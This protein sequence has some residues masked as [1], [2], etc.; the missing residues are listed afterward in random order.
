MEAVGR[1]YVG[2]LVTLT[3]VELTMVPNSAMNNVAQLSQAGTTFE[4]A[5]DAFVLTDA[6]NTCFAS[7]T[8]IWTYDVYNKVFALEPVAEGTPGGSC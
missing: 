5:G 1:P 3:N 4:A 6:V 2:T 7:I 8:G